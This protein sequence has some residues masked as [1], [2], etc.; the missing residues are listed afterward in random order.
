MHDHLNEIAEREILEKIKNP[1]IVDLH[2][3]F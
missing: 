2:Y 3:A 1:F